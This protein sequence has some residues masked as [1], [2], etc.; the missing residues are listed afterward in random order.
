VNSRPAGQAA[1]E[2]MD[3]GPILNV[4]GTLRLAGLLLAGEARVGRLRER[5]KQYLENREPLTFADGE[6]CCGR[7][8]ASALG[9]TLRPESAFQTVKLGRPSGGCRPAPETML[10]ADREHDI[11]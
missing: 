3:E 9:G 4:V 11:P 2:A 8:L 6:R 10:C 5:V 1:L 7:L